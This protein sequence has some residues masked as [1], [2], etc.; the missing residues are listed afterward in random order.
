MSCSLKN[1]QEYIPMKAFLAVVVLAIAVLAGVIAMQPEDFKVSRSLTM[2]AP[3]AVVFDQVNDLHKW[4]AWSP[5][6]KLDPNAKVSFEGPD[7]G[8]GA[9]MHWASDNQQVGEGNMKIVE[10]N[11]AQSIKFQL[12]FVKPM[13]GTDTAEFEFKPDG[14]QTTVTWSMYGKKNFVAKAMGM[15]FD[16]EKMVGGQF[17]QGLASMKQIAESASALAAVPTAT[18]VPAADAASAPASPSPAALTPAGR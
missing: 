13:A 4:E 10:S 16:C 18:T 12:D 14:N 7:A 17:E 1:R 9:S 6:A 15:F 8:T 3:A 2:N 5:W 11:L